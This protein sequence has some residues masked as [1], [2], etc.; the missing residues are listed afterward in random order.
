MNLIGSL[1]G[2]TDSIKLITYNFKFLTIINNIRLSLL[3]IKKTITK[4]LYRFNIVMIL[5]VFQ[6]F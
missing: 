3:K 2:M 6:S 4:S 1:K 5:G